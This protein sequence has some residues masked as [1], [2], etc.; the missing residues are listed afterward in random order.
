M[1]ETV[2]ALLGDGRQTC[3]A[4]PPAGKTVMS[5]RYA[6]GSIIIQRRHENMWQVIFIELQVIIIELQGIP[7]CARRIAHSEAVCEVGPSWN[8]AVVDVSNTVH[9]LTSPLAESMPAILESMGIFLARAT[10]SGFA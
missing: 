1:Q 7:V 4:V 2:T 6:H 10:T 8:W 3:M 5:G 9:P